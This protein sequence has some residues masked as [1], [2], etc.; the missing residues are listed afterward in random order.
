[1]IKKTLYLLVTILTLNANCTSIASPFGN[2]VDMENMP[3]VPEF[4]GDT[5]YSLDGRWEASR[6]EQS[7]RL[8]WEWDTSVSPAVLEVLSS[9]ET[10]PT[11]VYTLSG[12]GG[13]TYPAELSVDAG[14]FVTFR[15]HDGNTILQNDGNGWNEQNGFMSFDGP[16]AYGQEGWW[17]ETGGMI[18]KGE[19]G[20]NIGLNPDSVDGLLIPLTSEGEDNGTWQDW[21]DTIAPFYQDEY[22][23]S[24]TPPNT[25]TTQSTSGAFVNEAT[26][27]NIGL[28]FDD[29]QWVPKK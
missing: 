17:P 18:L 28:S 25:Q 22:L 27:L 21:L 11:Y 13:S 19:N 15:V 10:Y 29:G 24:W 5:S 14:G 3:T 9:S 12:R 1:M 6:I 23:S 8:R 2:Y 20:N 4:G 16:G 26:E 7:P